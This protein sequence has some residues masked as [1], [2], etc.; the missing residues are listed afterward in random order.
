M[1]DKLKVSIF[2]T[3]GV[4]TAPLEEALSHNPELEVVSQATDP[5]TLVESD[6]GKQPRPGPGV[7]QRLLRLSGLAALFYPELTQDCGHGLLQQPQSGVSHPGPPGRRPGSPARG[8]IPGR[9]GT[10]PGPGQGL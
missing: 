1:A 7:F 2:H 6:P 5:G 8:S 10:C 3:L 9:A 4:D